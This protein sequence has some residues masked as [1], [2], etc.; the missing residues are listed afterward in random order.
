VWS[1]IV[2]KED[3]KCVNIFAIDASREISMF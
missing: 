2:V 3:E 1:R